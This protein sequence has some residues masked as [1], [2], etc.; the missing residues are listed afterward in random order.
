MVRRQAAPNLLN[1]ETML[2]IAVV[3]A[4]LGLAK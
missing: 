4:P 2:F 1:A 3:C